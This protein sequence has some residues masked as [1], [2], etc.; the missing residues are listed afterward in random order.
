VEN[1][2][3]QN[4]KGKKKRFA[5]W[6]QKVEIHSLLLDIY[7]ITDDF[8]EVSPQAPSLMVRDMVQVSNDCFGYCS[9]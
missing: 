7:V 1:K 5:W 2:K 9:I 4:E 3:K 6:S 8:S